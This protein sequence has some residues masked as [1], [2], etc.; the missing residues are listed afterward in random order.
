LTA[1][2]RSKPKP[3]AL[4]KWRRGRPKNSLMN[5]IEPIL[6]HARKQ[7]HT[8]A[9]IE[10]EQ[11]ITYGELADR[12]LRTAGHLV[13]LGIVRGDQVALCLNDDSQNIV[14]LLAVAHLGATA[15]PIDARARPAERARIV[16]A[17]QLRLALATQESEKGIDCPKVVLDAAWHSAVAAADRTAAAAADWHTPIA[18][19]ASSGTTGVP[20]FTIATHFEYHFHVAA[21]LEVMPPRRHRY[22]STLPLYFS[23]GR[24]SCLCHLLRGDTLII[25]PALSSPAEF[26]ESV[27]RHRISVAFVVPSMLRQLLSMAGDHRLL[28]SEIDLLIAGGAPLFADEKLEVVQKVTPRFCEM[29]GTAAMGPMA[30]LQAGEIRERTTSVGRPFSFID[31]EIVNDSDGPLDPGATGHLRC[32][33]PGL[34][35][36]ITN[37]SSANSKDF[38]DGWY[39]PGELAAVDE[40]GYIFLQGRAS[41]VIFRGG[42]KIFP[43]EVE[44]VLQTHEAVA[45]AAV[46]GR[47]LSNN[48]QEPVAYVVARHPVTPGELLAHCRTR[49]TAFKV[50]REIHIVT[51]LPRNL[52]GKVDKRALVSQEPAPPH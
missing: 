20:K 29:Y 2:R 5:L 10:R 44:A 30:A 31:V 14:A 7:P 27:L 32:R 47:A 6:W 17:F 3:Q 24:L 21:Y 39:Y 46:V 45:E 36:P 23:A 34:T 13:K 40:L 25:H 43:S 11:T 42:A 28:R 41:E 19:L 18:A 52:S 22:L 33:G 9:I 12:V 50:P 1:Q 15:V 26:V 35:L 37:T 48:E 4:S 49:L 38:R 16:D 8:A 51:E